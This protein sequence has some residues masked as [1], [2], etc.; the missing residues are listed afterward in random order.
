MRIAFLWPLA[1][2]AAAGCQTDPDPDDTS[3]Q[4]T[5]EVD[6][7]YECGWDRN[8]PGDLEAGDR[9]VGD[10][11]GDLV[12]PDQCGEMYSIWDGHGGYMMVVSP[13]MW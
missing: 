9:A 1:L 2:L 13:P 12:G 11:V 4:D 10:V 7:P 8:D 3:H 6:D 5:V